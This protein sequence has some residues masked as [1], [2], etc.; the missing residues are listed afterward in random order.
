MQENILG[1]VRKCQSG[2]SDEIARL[3]AILNTT[4]QERATVLQ[5]WQARNQGKFS[6][7]SNQ[8]FDVTEDAQVTRSQQQLLDSLYFARIE[9][10]RVR[11][12]EAHKQTFKWVFG[13]V[14]DDGSRFDDY[15][16]WL[17][18]T[19]SSTNLFWISGKAG[20]G[21]RCVFPGLSIV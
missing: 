8:L 5:S 6:I 4:T 9:E 11:I 19:T 18:G 10:R 1:A 16:H 17:E 3:S 15:R 21:M 12:S 2:L 14:R 20:S 7:F 13:G